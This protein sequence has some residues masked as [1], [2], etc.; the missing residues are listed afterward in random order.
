MKLTKNVAST[1]ITTSVM[2]KAGL[3]VEAGTGVVSGQ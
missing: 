3:E 2:T 1:A